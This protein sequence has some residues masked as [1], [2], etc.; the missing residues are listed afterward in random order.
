M[1]R[2]SNT[3]V[4]PTSSFFPCPCLE[5]AAQ[6]V[7][8]CALLYFAV[9]APQTTHA[10]TFA[11]T[12]GQVMMTRAP[13]VLQSSNVEAEALGLGPP[14]LSS[15]MP[16]PDDSPS[17]HATWNSVAQPPMQFCM[18]QPGEPQQTEAWA[19]PTMQF[20][21][22][23][24]CGP[25]QMESWAQPPMQ[26]FMD[27]HDGP[28]Q[29]E[30][31]VNPLF[32]DEADGPA[33]RRSWADE[34][35]EQALETEM[36]KEE[37]D[38]SWWGVSNSTLRRRRRQRATAK[39]TTL[40]GD[41]CAQEFQSP[42]NQSA[43]L[44]EQ[45][46]TGGEAQ[47]S[48]VAAFRRLSFNSQESCRAAQLALEEAGTE[49][50]VVLLKALRGHV[51][52][53]VKSMHAN[54]VIQRA[55]ELLPSSATNFIAEELLGIGKEVACHR[56]GCRIFCR[57]LEQGLLEEPSRHMLLEE[58]LADTDSLARHAYGNFVIRHCLEFGHSWHRQHIGA[59]LCTNLARTALDL[60]GSRVIETAL[61]FCETTQKQA[62]AETLL[63]DPEQLLSLTRD[64][65]GRFVV[66][67]L[68]RTPGDWQERIA[69]ILRPAIRTL[70]ESKNGR[71]VL[72]ALQA[73]DGKRNNV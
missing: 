66:K 35:E 40:A 46:R 2:I 63:A 51:W 6:A 33:M 19:Q 45:V 21:I 72:Q 4:A 57:L 34:S 5:T 48:A 71:P 61:E 37:V 67:A 47:R 27:Q 69:A 10:E 17:C 24:T 49:E 13:A 36:P 22:G 39:S 50:A 53:A 52:D 18:G 9:G 12:P 20:F 32:A 54:Y 58:V 60:N 31:S 23:Q 64:T 16:E 70:K 55:I 8:C 62:I 25:Q 41:V 56:F 73:F 15:Y 7:P 3:D 38:A 11:A 65:L 29:M 43:E 1:P 42:E 44:L 26:F 28:Q 59:T 68:L 14:L 30:P